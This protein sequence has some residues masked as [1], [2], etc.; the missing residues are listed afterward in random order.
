MFDMIIQIWEAVE[1]V[2]VPL[3]VTSLGATGLTIFAPNSHSVKIFDVV[4]KV[5]NAVAG[6]IHKN[7]NAK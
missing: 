4:L 2:V 5:L 7:K 6:N 1:P 3:A